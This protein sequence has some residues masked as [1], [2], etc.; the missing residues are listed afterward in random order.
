MGNSYVVEFSYSTVVKAK[1]RD[2]AELKALKELRKL[3][4][5][6]LI[7]SMVIEVF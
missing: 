2:D 5:E 7:S 1:D 3:D 4:H 6:I